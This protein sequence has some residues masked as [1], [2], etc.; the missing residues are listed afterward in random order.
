M[1]DRPVNAW[2]QA[3]SAVAL[4]GA[5]AVGF[6]AISD[7]PASERDREQKAAT[8][9]GGVPT[10]SDR[11]AGRVSGSQLC[12]ALNQSELASWLGTPGELPKSAY[13]N[14][15]SVGTGKNKIAYPS[16]RIEFETYTVELSASYDRFPVDEETAAFIGRDAHL[17]KVLR[18]PAV[19]YSTETMGIRF[20][21]D[22][23]DAQST[24][25][26]PAEALSV[27][28]DAKNRGGSWELV[29]WRNGG[30]YPDRTVLLDVA[31]HVLPVIPGF[32]SGAKLRQETPSS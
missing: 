18:R 20:R 26:K 2:G 8:C 27:A 13:G 31:E 14:G 12:R 3:I 28:F 4:V 9:S 24:Q 5:L 23:S 6:W 19:F 17:Q 29:V 25:G 32:D 1:T 30:G 16:A 11:A 22:G 10:K 7:S 21:L 15:G